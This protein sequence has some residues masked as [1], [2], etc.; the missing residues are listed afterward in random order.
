MPGYLIP[1]QETL[2]PFTPTGNISATTVADAIIELD[3]EKSPI[4]SPNF[5]GT[6]SAANIAVSGN[7]SASSGNIA[8]NLTVDTNTLYVDSANNRVGIGTTNPVSTLHVTGGYSLIGQYNTATLHPSINQG[9]VSVSWNRSAGA[10]ETNFV[11]LFENAVNGFE[12]LQKT[13]ADTANPLMLLG[14]NN[15]F[16]TGGVQRMIIDSSGRVTMPYQPYFYARGA[17]SSYTLTNGADFPFNNAIVN[18]GSHFNTSTYRFTAP[19]AGK[20]LFT[21]S[22][23]VNTATNRMTIKVNNTSYNNLNMIS[24]SAWSQ[25]VVLSLNVNDY[26]SV[27]DWQS[28]SG[29]S[30][31]MGHSHFSGYFLG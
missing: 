29:S 23:F 12:F 1:A 17:E 21:T 15:V 11:N 7:L 31:Y 19:I 2:N 5:T 4:A 13:G 18:V 24:G 26:V 8:G 16:Y 9:G 27:G 30:V 28:L 3:N 10:A 14:S 6:A 25:S 20:Y 22:L